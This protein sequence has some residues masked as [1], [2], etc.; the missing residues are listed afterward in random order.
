[1]KDRIKLFGIVAA[2][3]MIGLS[4]AACGGETIIVEGGGGAGPNADIIGTWRAVVDGVP[5][6]VSITASNW[7]ITTPFFNDIGTYIRTGN[8]ARLFSSN[9]WGAEVGWAELI[10]HNTIRL[11]LTQGDIPGTFTLHRA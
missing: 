2:V 7:T 10:S 3:A 8:T 6:T 1:M 4:A 11:T 5:V 9:L